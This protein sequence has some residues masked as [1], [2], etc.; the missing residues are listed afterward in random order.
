MAD[1][2]ERGPPAQSG[3]R[4]EAVEQGVVLRLVLLVLQLLLLLDGGAQG[5]GVHLPLLLLLLMLLD[6]PMLAHCS[7]HALQ[8][9]MQG[10]HVLEGLDGPAG[11]ATEASK[12]SDASVQWRA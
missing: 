2:Y 12:R 11:K 3:G 5:R 10:I 9:P 4:F 6:G 8:G 1:A 7:G